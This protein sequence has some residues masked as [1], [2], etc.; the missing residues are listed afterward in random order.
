MT[1]L[2]LGSETTDA[3]ERV[4][5]AAPAGERGIVSWFDLPA[6]ARQNVV[7]ACRPIPTLGMYCVIDDEHVEGNEEFL[8]C[9]IQDTVE[10]FLERFHGWSD[11]HVALG[12]PSADFRDPL[13]IGL[14]TA[15]IEPHFTEDS[16]FP[17]L[18]ALIRLTALVCRETKS[19]AD[20]P[21]DE[22]LLEIYDTYTVGSLSSGEQPW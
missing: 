6:V 8:R 15:G 14:R 4:A 11:I 19:R 22:D 18:R 21:E 20:I 13:E 9:A 12:D 2:A 10:Q 1:T 7:R 5:M 17:G 3:A 16:L